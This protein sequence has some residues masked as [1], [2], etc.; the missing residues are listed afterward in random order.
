MRRDLRASALALLIL[1]VVLGLAYPLAL[2]GISQAVFGN[3][4]DGSQITQDGRVVGSKLL[5]QDFSGDPPTSRAALRPPAI[6]ATSPTSP[7]S[8]PTAASSPGS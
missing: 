8:D 7:T 2:T 3:Q 6:R 1:T 5:G 4:A